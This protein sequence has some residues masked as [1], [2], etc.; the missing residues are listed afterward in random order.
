MKIA[1]L[2]WGSLLWENSTEKAKKFNA[3]VDSWK[4]PPD[5][6]G[7]SLRIEF[8]RISRTRMG[9][10]TLVLDYEN[11]EACPVA[12]ALSIRRQPE[13]TIRDLQD[14]EGTARNNI[15][16]YFADD[17]TETVC[18]RAHAD[19]QKAVSAWARQRN[20][21]VV[22]WT[23][24]K[25]NFEKH[26]KGEFSVDSA[27]RYVQNLEESAQDEAVRYIRQAPTFVKTPLRRR[28]ESESWFLRSS[29]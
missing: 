23:G 29:K 24:L 22:V 19:T 26:G 14:R 4:S 16:C 6:E 12:Y 21:D 20:I 27:A 13:D 15:G 2:G 8:S 9:A 17:S 10:L 7:P 3:H 18:A 1:I 11:G 25:P 5:N 28:L